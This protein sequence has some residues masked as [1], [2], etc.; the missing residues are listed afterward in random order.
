MTVLFFATLLALVSA[1]W[2]H[3]AS[4]SASK[5]VDV[6]LYG[7]VETRVGATAMALAWVGTLLLGVTFFWALAFEL[8]VR[9]VLEVIDDDSTV[10][11]STVSSSLPL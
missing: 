10:M 6:L 9:V 4:A 1:I 7:A 5:L 2:Q 11:S 3:M 8:S